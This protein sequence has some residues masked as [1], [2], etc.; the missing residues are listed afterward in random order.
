MNSAT[1]L[2]QELKISIIIPCFNMEAY[3]EDTLKS[4]INQDYSNYEIIVVDGASTDNTMN[5]IKKYEQHISKII[6][7]K[8][9]GQYNAI[10]KGM[11]QAT[12]EIMA[13]INADDVYFPW[14]LKHVGCF[15][16]KYPQYSWV[17]G[18][19]S[20]MSEN[21]FIH[22]LNRNII[23]KPA[24]MVKNGWFR[25]NLY[26]YLQ[27]EG[28]FWRKEL[29]EA[30]NG[31]NEHYKLA[32]DF[33]L[34]IKFALHAELISFGIPLASF[35]IRE[36]SRSKAQKGSYEAE[37]VKICRPLKK[38]AFFKNY[39]GRKGKAANILMRKSTIK[40]GKI[41]YFSVLENQW[42]LKEK[43]TSMSTH[44]ATSILSLH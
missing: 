30:S 18:S 35:R 20:L 43:Y 19:T 14:T 5:T 36:D 12:G 39:F 15:F 41:Y 16:A 26:G 1:N 4:V 42:V 29:W 11:Q 37:V 25:E 9:K 8:D 2:N 34:W 38:P 7:E 6:S 44:S 24:A 33:D 27:Q 3:I 28:M 40:K 10:N 31:I 22:G 32:A 23:A 21:G 13:W 17:S